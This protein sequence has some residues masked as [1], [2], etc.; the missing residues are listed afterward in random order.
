MEVPTVIRTSPL[1]ARRALVSKHLVRGLTYQ[2]ILLELQ[3]EFPTA[4]M[5]TVV[6]DVKVLLRRW[7]A[8]QLE[9]INDYMAL[10]LKRLDELQAAIWDEALQ[11]NPLAIDRVLRISDKRR[12]L[13]NIVRAQDEKKPRKFVLTWATN[14][15]DQPEPPP[16]LTSG[17]IIEEE[18]NNAVLSS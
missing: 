6:S 14:D 1:E 18:E 4:H 9:N 13:L 11:G 10:E 15:E 7:Q 3:K 12:E 8:Q 2:E 5:R 17:E 16:M